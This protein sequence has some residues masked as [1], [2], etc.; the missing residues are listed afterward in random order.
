MCAQPTEIPRASKPEKIKP[1]ANSPHQMKAPVAGVSRED[2]G[3]DQTHRNPNFTSVEVKQKIRDPLLRSEKTVKDKFPTGVVVQYRR[4][5]HILKCGR[6]EP[7]GN[8]YRKRRKIGDVHR[9]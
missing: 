5:H 7:L 8:K 9:M 4:T 3:G 1:I 6:C 2:Y